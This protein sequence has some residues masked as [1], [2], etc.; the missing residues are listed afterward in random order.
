MV[1]KGWRGMAFMSTRS[2]SA[3]R[4]GSRSKGDA[5]LFRGPRGGEA[6]DSGSTAIASRACFRVDRCSCRSVT[7]F[8]RLAPVGFS[9]DRTRP[10]TLV[11]TGERRGRAPRP[12]LARRV[13]RGR[14][15]LR[16]A[17]DMDEEDG[18]RFAEPGAATRCRP[19]GRRAGRRRADPLEPAPSRANALSGAATRAGFERVRT[20]EAFARI[21]AVRKLRGGRAPAS[22]CM[23]CPGRRACSARAPST[24]SP[25]RHPAAHRHPCRASAPGLVAR[26]RAAAAACQNRPAPLPGWLSTPFPGIPLPPLV[27]TPSP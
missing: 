6:D 5:S 1:R 26:G 4:F 15:P 18:R 23:T 20:D 11:V 9:R 19:G 25:H 8:R 14:P 17:E 21:P 22:R 2:K 7:S 13:R 3:C 24:A 10:R 16:G 27:R 12:A